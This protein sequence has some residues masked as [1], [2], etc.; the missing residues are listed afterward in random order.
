MSVAV[1]RDRSPRS[2]GTTV[3]SVGTSP[4]TVRGTTL[5]N[6][7]PATPPAGCNKTLASGS[8][9]D[10]IDAVTDRQAPFVLCLAGEFTGGGSP[11][12]PNRRGVGPYWGNIVIEGRTNFTLRGLPGSIIQGIANDEQYPPLTAPPA[13]QHP[14]DKSILIKVADSSRIVLEGLTIDGHANGSPTLNRLVWLQRVTDSTVRHNVIRNAGGECVRLKSNSQ[15]NE[16]HNNDISGCGFY[17]FKLQKDAGLAKNGEGIYLGTDPFQITTSQINLHTYW[18]LDAKLVTD[19]TSFNRIHHN[20]IAPG[21]A[22]TGYGNECVDIKEDWVAP[23]NDIPG[24]V[25]R[26]LPGNNVVADNDCSGQYDEE[27]GAF[28]AR[29]PNNT[30]EHNTIHGEVLGAA[31][32][33]RGGEKE[34]AGTKT[35]FVATGNRVRLNKIESFSTPAALKLSDD[36]L[37]DTTAGGVCGNVDAQGATTFSFSPTKKVVNQPTCPD[38]ATPAGPRGAVGPQV[39]P[40][41]NN[42]TTPPAVAG[43][44]SS[45][46]PPTTAAKTTTTLFVP[47]TTMVAADTSG[48]FQ[49]VDGVVAVEAEQASVIAAG[50]HSWAP[51]AAPTGFV[52]TGAMEATPNDGLRTSAATGSAEL[53]FLVHVDQPG[54]YNVWLRGT[55][56][57]GSDDSVY[58]GVNNAQFGEMALTAKTWGWT[59]EPIVIA[60]P[61]IQVISI[62]MR[63]DGSIVDRLVLSDP[64]FVPTGTGPAPSPQG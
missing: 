6:A 47:S 55:G 25:A 32:R 26:G 45:T 34:I 5:P 58:V 48:A 7:T 20:R 54:K 52:G 11:P 35:A 37:P 30:F 13:D 9:Q 38:D 46:A 44:A 62:W 49:A 41:T 8:I 17:Q 19:R 50:R 39:A 4:P 22:G 23:R 21:P 24:D 57:T 15:R 59:R 60:T 3:G 1:V 29:G 14:R 64:S 27:S 31:F 18:G 36:Q 10:A 61:G 16:I 53:R 2:A 33:L 63:E 28:D 42:G 43:G 56:A 51:A 40:T 12:S